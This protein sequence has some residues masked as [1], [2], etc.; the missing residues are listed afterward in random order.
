MLHPFRRLDFWTFRR[1]LCLVASLPCCLLFP[2]A[3][4]RADPRP[5]TSPLSK[6]EPRFGS[7]LAD[8][9]CLPASGTPRVW[10]WDHVL[11]D[12]TNLDHLAYAAVAGGVIADVRL[13]DSVAG[14]ADVAALTGARLALRLHP[15]RSTTRFWR[16]G[17]GAD[18]AY[19]GPEVKEHVESLARKLWAAR[20]VA[21]DVPIDRVFIDCETWRRSD[22]TA[23]DRR[24]WNDAILHKHN[25]V[26]QAI[27]S[28]LGDV[29]IEWYNYS[30][31]WATLT[32]RE[33][34]AA[35]SLSL[36]PPGADA[37]DELRKALDFQFARGLGS[38][39]AYISLDAGWRMVNG[40]RRWSWF[41]GSDARLAYRFGRSLT[42]YSLRSVHDLVDYSAF[43]P[44]NKHWRS[45]C[46]ALFRGLLGFPP[47]EGGTEGGSPQI[48]QI[49]ADEGVK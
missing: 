7:A 11:W 26:V 19:L 1:F 40:R 31:E 37:I 22:P 13:P 45:H 29:R 8:L 38:T 34:T 35:A 16:D 23:A 25:L 47:Y 17:P 9:P 32:L 2:S 27:R 10:G 14:A 46:L 41:H 6:G 33:E 24:A 44:A 36:Y 4:I 28:V 39:T 20:S 18:P 12:P 15:Y 3:S 48:A 30:P 5:V 49:I 43:H 21:G 42:G